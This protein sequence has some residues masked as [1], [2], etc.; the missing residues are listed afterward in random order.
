MQF[1]VT[2]V[3]LLLSLC[4]HPVSGHSAAAMAFQASVPSTAIRFPNRRELAR[5]TVSSG[6]SEG[7]CLSCLR[8]NA[9]YATR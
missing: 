9:S 6:Y 2:F 1:F 4:H 5:E 8:M 3:S 7:A